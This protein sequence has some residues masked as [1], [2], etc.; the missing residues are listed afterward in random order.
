MSNSIKTN[1]IVF[2][3]D[4]GFEFIKKHQKIFLSAFIFIV[5]S[6]IG[7]TG[8]L[9]YKNHQRKQAYK[10]LTN[11]LRYYDANVGNEKQNDE[12]T[13]TFKTNKE[14]WTKVENSFKKN[15]E[16]YQNTEACSY[17]FGISIRSS[18]KPR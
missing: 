7:V 13:V 18:F 10:A 8:Y 16:E 2:W 12:S 6:S 15:Y 17:V 9:F 14:K 4:N 11:S 1:S 5:I 3:I